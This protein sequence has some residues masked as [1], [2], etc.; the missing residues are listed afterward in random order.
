MNDMIPADGSPPSLLTQIIAG[1]ARHGLTA[2]AGVL[3]AHGALAGSQQDAFVGIGSGIALWAGTV[4][5]SIIQKR[6][7]KKAT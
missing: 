6:N 7:V 1:I 3:T 2:L 4:L 5:W